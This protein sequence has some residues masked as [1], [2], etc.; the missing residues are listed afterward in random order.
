MLTGV[1]IAESLRVGGVLKDVPVQVTKIERS[2]A[3]GPA[4]GQ[5]RVWTLLD[6]RAAE[7][8]ADRLPAALAA[9]LAPVGGWYANF[10]TATEA[11]TVFAGRVFRYP[12]GDRAR[13]AEEYARSAG[14]PEAQLDWAD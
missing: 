1:L 14:V 2:E 10:N 11:F 7:A 5:P 3:P 13:R 6:F 12:R 4:D 8:D 9:C